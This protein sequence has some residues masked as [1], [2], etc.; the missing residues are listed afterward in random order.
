MPDQFKDYF[1]RVAEVFSRLDYTQIEK[2]KN[3][4]VEARDKGKTIFIF[5]NGGSGANA[6]HIAGD[7]VKG[8]SYKQDKK[9]RF[10][11]LNDNFSSLA[12]ISNDISYDDA[13]VMQLENFLNEGDL[14]IGLSGSGNSEN[15][16]R[17]IEL[18]NK[19]GAKTL[20]LSAYTG[21][22]LKDLASCFVH[23]P[24]NDMEI[25][26]DFQMMIFHT[27]KQ[28]IISDQNGSLEDMGDKYKSRIK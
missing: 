11:C 24:I 7:Y 23:T 12:A 21:G 10:L 19:K 20:A 13:F 15:V 2:A 4:L 5:G 18:A 16:V 6:S 3:L 22:K 1:N 17:A 14:V 28:S 26:E 25:A 27:I 9:F 8:A